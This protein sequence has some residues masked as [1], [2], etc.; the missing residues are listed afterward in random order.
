MTALD[1]ELASI[2][3]N[4]TGIEDY[5]MRK[6]AA[7]RKR[8]GTAFPYPYAIGWRRALKETLTWD[9]APVGDGISWSL[10]P[11]ATQFTLSVSV[12]LS[13]QQRQV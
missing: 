8:R 10:A 3:R 12:L 4:R 1:V 5:I 7:I 9:G 11:G 6:A 2:C 13:H